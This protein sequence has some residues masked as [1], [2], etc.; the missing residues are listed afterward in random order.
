MPFKSVALFTGKFC[1]LHNNEL[2]RDARKFREEAVMQMRKVIRGTV[3]GN[4]ISIP[5]TLLLRHCSNFCLFFH[6]EQLI[7]YEAVPW[8]IHNFSESIQYRIF[9]TELVSKAHLFEIRVHLMKRLSTQQPL[10]FADH[11]SRSNISH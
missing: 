4:G 5:T 9:I 2:E 6:K 11:Q 3:I 10:A 1:H 8:F 7:H